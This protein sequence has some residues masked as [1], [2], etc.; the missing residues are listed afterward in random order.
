[1][2]GSRQMSQAIADQVVADLP[3]AL[4]HQRLA[5][6][7]AGLG[8]IGDIQH[9]CNGIGIAICVLAVLPQRNHATAGAHQ[10]PP[11]A[12]KGYTCFMP[13][14]V[15]FYSVQQTLNVIEL[16]DRAVQELQTDHPINN[17]LALILIDNAV[18]LLV[19][20]ECVGLLKNDEMYQQMGSQIR[21][22]VPTSE[23][24]PEARRIVD[25]A[26]TSRERLQGEER[27]LRSKLSFL[28][29]LDRISPAERDFILWIHDHRNRL[30]HTGLS[31]N[32]IAR[33]AAGKYF[34]LCCQLFERLSFSGMI[35]Y[36]SN[37]H[38]TATTRRYFFAGHSDKVALLSKESLLNVIAELR[39]QCPG[40]IAQL[41]DAL[42]QHAVARI[43]EIEEGFNFILQNSH[44]GATADKVL[45]NIQSWFYRLLD[46]KPYRFSR[47]SHRTHKDRRAATSLPLDRWKRRA[48]AIGKEGN[49]FRAVMIYEALRRD[50]VC[51]EEIILFSAARIDER[52][53]IEI[54]IA[55]GK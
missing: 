13:P 36:S 27:E 2:H 1:M 45:V 5:C 29:R 47:V 31:A 44:P 54:D 33:A 6:R 20:R 23:M 12:K 49:A 37:D 28:K 9:S 40:D 4:D 22:R 15:D 32:E 50:L 11:T 43:G 7:P 3:K 51:I 18:E 34:T 52:I 35:S 30:Y 10:E 38:Y 17:R 21:M 16:M 39:A 24:P 42:A 25:K 53:Q 14:G 19:Y 26:M 46:D 41:P 48:N 8:V 55:R